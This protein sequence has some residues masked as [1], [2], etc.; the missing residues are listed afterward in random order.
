MQIIDTA[1]QLTE[2]AFAI[3]VL[4]PFVRTAFWVLIPQS[5]H[6]TAEGEQGLTAIERSIP[7]AIQAVPA[8]AEPLTLKVKRPDYEEM[9]VFDL[10]R[11]CSES[12]VPWRNAHGKNRHLKRAEMVTALAGL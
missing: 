7:I 3:T 6:L 9:K 11:H 5:Q 4:I 10:R 8:P 2:M 12:G 1:I